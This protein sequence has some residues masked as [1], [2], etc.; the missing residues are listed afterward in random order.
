MNILLFNIRQL[1]SH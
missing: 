1:N